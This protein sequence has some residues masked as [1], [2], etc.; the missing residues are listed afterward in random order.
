MKQLC[1]ALTLTALAAALGAISPAQAQTRGPLSMEEIRVMVR[2]SLPPIVTQQGTTGILIGLLRDAKL[3]TERP[4]S[5]TFNP[6]EVSKAVFGRTLPSKD[7]LCNQPLTNAGDVDED[8]CNS[9]SGAPNGDGAFTALSFSKHIQLGNITILKRP[10]RKDITPTSLPNVKL[11]DKG[12]YLGAMKFAVDTLG[13]SNAEIPTPPG[14]APLPVNTL[15]LGFGADGRQ[16]GEIALMR[17]VHIK[18]A[19]ELPKGIPMAVTGGG[20]DEATAPPELK[21][22]LLPGEATFLL[23]DKGVQGARIEGWL[24][25]PIDPKLDPKLGKSSDELIDEI[26]Q[27]LFAHGGRKIARLSYSFAFAQGSNPN[28]EDPKSPQCARCGGVLRPVLRVA[29]YALDAKNPTQGEVAAP[30]LVHDFDLGSTETRL[31]Q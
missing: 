6:A 23:D 12:A 31:M 17:V 18:R 11:D 19:A 28:P 22:V 10:A 26:A 14:D 3:D 20:L 8:E 21:H 30:G 2:D 27:D 29:L 13:L 4:L 15:T 25:M 7:P 9:S 5:K 1:H 16:L 24:S